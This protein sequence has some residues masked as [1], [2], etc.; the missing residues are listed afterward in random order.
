MSKKKVNFFQSKT[1]DFQK[2]MQNII[3]E[4]CKELK[5]R[6]RHAIPLARHGQNA[7]I[8]AARK[9]PENRYIDCRRRAYRAFVRL[10]FEKRRCGL[11]AFGKRHDLRAHI[12]PHHGKITVQHG[13][14]YQKILADYGKTGAQQYLNAN[15]SALAAY[16][17]ICT[18]IDCDF[19]EKDAVI[20]AYHEEEQQTLKAE[21]NAYKLLGMP[22][23]K[24]PVKRSLFQRSTRSF[25]RGR[26]SFTR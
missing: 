24:A 15:R 1:S 2:K 16:R 18:G 8:S 25:Y 23:Q 11:S 12:R 13:C 19:E 3:A 7:P 17:Q 14:C 22:V 20:Y 6:K 26:H 5:R 9:R 4:F 21:E 10:F